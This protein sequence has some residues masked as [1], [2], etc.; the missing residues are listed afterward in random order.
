[1]SELI[2]ELRNEKILFV[3]STGGHLAQLVRIS[4]M[5][6][7]GHGSMWVTFDNAQSQSL[8]SNFDHTFVPYVAPRD[9]LGVAKAQ[10]TVRKLVKSNNFTATVS[11]GA[12]LALASHV[13]PIGMRRVYIESVSRLNGPSLTGRILSKVPG[14]E[15]FTQHQR[16]SDAKW[17]HEFSVMDAYT[18]DH[19]WRAAA[20]TPRRIFVTL[21]TIRPYRFDSLVDTIVGS[22]GPDTELVWQLGVTDRDDLPGRVYPEM[23]SAEFDRFVTESD[24]VISHAG[25]GTLM[26]LMDMGVPTLAVPRRA[27]RGEHVDNH[28]LQIVEELRRRELVPTAEVAE[29]DAGMLAKASAIRVVPA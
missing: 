3:A 24:L 15:L 26:K 25:V 11:T 8:V 13:V 21:G 28:Q 10:R 14:V 9:Y 19:N 29:I 12:G 4:E 20:P 18:R 27:E 16:W 22:V 6:Q 5:I 7:P 17:K 1:M 23:K 2:D